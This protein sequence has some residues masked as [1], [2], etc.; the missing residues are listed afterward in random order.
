MAKPANLASHATSPPGIWTAIVFDPELNNALARMHFL[1]VGD[2]SA[3][4][5]PAVPV[6]AKVT[7][8]LVASAIDVIAKGSPQVRRINS[9][10]DGEISE[11]AVGMFY[12]VTSVCTIT[13]LQNPCHS[14]E[15]STR[16]PDHKSTISSFD[17]Q[18]GRLT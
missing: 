2:N 13:S 15:W 1:V 18:S 14:S 3:K 10:V 5:Q 8:E 9:E 16:F 11:E 12:E 6:I 7:E 17:A 4:P